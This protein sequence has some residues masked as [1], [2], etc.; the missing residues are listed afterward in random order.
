MAVRGEES[1]S[2]ID[3][4]VR[5]TLEKMVGE[6]RSSVEDV[7]H[8]VDSQLK[9]ALQSV[10][11]DVN[12]ISFLPFIQKTITELQQSIEEERPA[13]TPAPAAAPEGGNAERV[14]RAVQ[15]VERGKSG[16]SARL[17]P[18]RCSSLA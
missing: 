6:I 17:R 4:H 13:F 8:A 7:R 14:K 9:A 2:S 5:E 15:T 18:S 11:A 3:S 12:A 1:A 16:R 10:Q